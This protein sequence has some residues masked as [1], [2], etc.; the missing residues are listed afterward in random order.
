MDDAALTEALVRWTD[1]PLLTLL[2]RALLIGLLLVL[3]DRL[4]S[5]LVM[6]TWRAGGD[7]RRSLA[8][9]RPMTR[10]ILGAAGLFGV[11][12]PLHA[13]N[14]ISALVLGL[15]VGA[16]ATIWG[17]EPLRNV[18]GGLALVLSRPFEM[19]SEIAIGEVSG[20][21]ESIE[22]TRIRLRTREGS[23]V[24]VPTRLFATMSVRTTAPSAPALPVSVEVPLRAE[25]AVEDAVSALRDEAYL[26]AYACTA[27][28]VQ[29]EVVG[30]GRA[31]VTATPVHPS[32]A[33]SLR[34]DL[35]A[36]AESLCR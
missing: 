4:V 26:S 8:W 17:L 34:S 31:R 18:A 20:V 24:H 30:P 28:P 33:G 19:G 5:R 25:Q 7:R 36:R 23:L 15:L 32:D 22:L 10:L 27:A 35:A 3:L 11:F 9:A 1:W 16:V 29:I 14:P 21:V 13:A 6:R 2:V 12:A